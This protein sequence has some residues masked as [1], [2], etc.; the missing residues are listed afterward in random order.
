MRVLFDQAHQSPSLDRCGG[1]RQGRPC[2]KVLRVAEDVG[3]DVLLTT[4]NS[5][6]Y[7]QNLNDRRIAI[8][9]L[10]RNRW[11]SVQ[12]MLPKIAAAVDGATPGSYQTIEIPI[13]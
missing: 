13:R 6:E 3:F 10:T 7:Q 1:T 4:D 9:V 11:R 12:Q 8:V 5:I 2:S